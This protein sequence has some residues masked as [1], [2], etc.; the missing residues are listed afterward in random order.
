MFLKNFKKIIN[1]NLKGTFTWNIKKKKFLIFHVK[2]K[3]SKEEKNP[4]SYLINFLPLYF[5][6]FPSSQIVIQMFYFLTKATFR[7]K[8]AW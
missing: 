7:G 4:D 6:G 8:V 5:K 2:V 3:Y 1:L